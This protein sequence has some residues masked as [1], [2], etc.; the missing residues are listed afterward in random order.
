MSG[1][2]KETTR[3]LWNQKNHCRVSNSHPL[4]PILSQD[5]P[6][7]AFPY[8]FL[9]LY[10]NIILPST[11]GCS[12]W[13]LPGGFCTKILCISAVLHMHHMFQQSHSSSSDRP[14][15]WWAVQIMK[16]LI[17][18][19]SPFPS[20]P[21]PRSHADHLWSS[22]NVRTPHN[23][24]LC[25]KT[26]CHCDCMRCWCYCTNWPTKG[27]LS[28]FNINGSLTLSVARDIHFTP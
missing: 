2:L 7:R 5:N 9:R 17:M 28:F 8:L 4:L 21:L 18:Q 27:L 10:F 15:G 14:N 23:M 20:Y 12:K 6:V 3:I 22:R 25:S 24:S 26:T 1:K 11:S 19:F 13:L 16:L